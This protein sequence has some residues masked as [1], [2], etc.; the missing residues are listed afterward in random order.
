M[1][2]PGVNLAPKSRSSGGCRLNAIAQLKDALVDLSRVRRIVRVEGSLNVA[3]GFTAMPPVLNG[4]S[5]LVNDIF[6]ERGRHTRM[7]YGCAEMPLD[8]ASLVV[9]WA[10]VET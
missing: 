7:I 1:P 10:E 9:L 3:P 8:C 6:A 2:A 4:A 5:D